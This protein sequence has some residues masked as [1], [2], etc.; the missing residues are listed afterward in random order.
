MYVDIKDKIKRKELLILLEKKYFKYK[1]FKRD[2]I[3]NSELPIH[4]YTSTKEIG[5]IGSANILKISKIKYT[6]YDKAIKL[7]NK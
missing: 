5:M 4:I 1:G 2:N 3:I 7:I 6:D